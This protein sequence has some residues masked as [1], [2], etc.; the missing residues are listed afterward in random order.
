MRFPSHSKTHV[1]EIAQQFHK[2][3][4]LS[5]YCQ[6]VFVAI[7]HLLLHPALLSRYSPCKNSLS[8]YM[9]R[10]R[11]LLFTCVLLFG[12]SLSF[13]DQQWVEVTSPHFSL[14][15]DAGEKRGREVLVRFEQM[16]TAFGLLFQKVNVNTPVKLQIVAYRNSK[17]LR[18]VAPLFEGK[19]I[20]LSG[21]FLGAGTHGMPANGEDRQYIALDLSAEDSWGV[22]FHEYAHLLLNS[23]FPPS[24]VWFDEG[25]AEYCS[26]LKVTKKEIDIG[27]VRPDLPQTLLDNRWLKLEDLFGVKHNSKIYNRDDRRSVFYAQSWITVHYFMSKGA[28]MMKPVAAYNNLVRNDRV[29]VRD[30]VRQAFGM[31]P[32]N[33]E[34]LVSEYFKSGRVVYFPV[35]A[36][37]GIDDIQVSSRPVNDDEVKVIFADLDFHTRD[38]R[39]RGM[40][41]FREILSKQPDNPV[42][43]RALGYAALQKNDLEKA[44]EYFRRAAVQSSQDPQVHY[45]LALLMSRQNLSS[46]KPPDDVDAMKKELNAAISLDPGYAEAYNLLGLT[47]S[48]DPKQKDEAVNDLKKAI[49]L[50]PRNGWYSMNLA[51]VY[52]RHQETDQAVSLLTGLKDNPDPQLSSIAQQQLQFIENYNH[53]VTVRSEP[54]EEEKGNEQPEKREVDKDNFKPEEV[55]KTQTPPA[56]YKPEP[57]LFLKGVLLSVDCSQSPSATLTI[58]SGGKKWKM[59]AADAKKLIVMGADSLSCSWTNRKVAVNYRKA[60]ENEG[61]LATL[62]LE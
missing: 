32:E 33:L 45:L 38:Y 21:F 17:E 36:P 59:I 40:A 22:V 48:Y 53:P 23:N 12:A 29:P 16:R 10:F 50:D 51:G 55:N 4:V 25:F 60:G 9:Y 27:L 61:K 28:A 37:P 44:G 39:D 1:F 31:E 5:N 7:L 52:I 42:A 41:A 6:I 35:P 54:A 24:P 49:A 26:S 56:P 8:I 19:P 30:A 2:P 58:S 15:T 34:K 62:E 43:N 46:G 11:F 47:L 13:A 3:S 57:V 14:L 18:Q 20:T